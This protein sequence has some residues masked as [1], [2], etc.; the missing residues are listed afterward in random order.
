MEGGI[1]DSHE[2]IDIG[3]F[4]EATIVSFDIPSKERASRIAVQRLLRGR[5]DTKRVNGEAVTYSYPGM[6]DEGGL[7]LGQSVFLFPADLAS[8]LIVKLRELK[9]SHR[10]W[11]VM[12]KD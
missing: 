12:M 11:D 6:L 1:I 10:Y 8:R 2:S 5:R 9:I 3:G 4:Q 7:R